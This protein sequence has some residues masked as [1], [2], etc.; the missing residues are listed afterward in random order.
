[1]RAL[2]AAV[3]HLAG[4]ARAFPAEYWWLVAGLLVNRLGTWQLEHMW[5]LVTWRRRPSAH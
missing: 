1:M 2:R 4:S 3:R 5:G